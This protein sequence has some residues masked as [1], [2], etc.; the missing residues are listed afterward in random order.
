MIK[1]NYIVLL[2]ILILVFLSINQKINL[3]SS[4]RYTSI[5]NLQDY[6]SK[7]TTTDG[8]LPY[9]RFVDNIKN[10]KENTIYVNLTSQSPYT[11][12][13]F[14]KNNNRKYYGDHEMK[15]DFKYFNNASNLEL[16]QSLNP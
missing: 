6:G 4:L 11:A 12:I 5:E 8:P 15:M 16:Y 9:E 3:I 1:T 7:T 14:N 2:F 10:P 13:D